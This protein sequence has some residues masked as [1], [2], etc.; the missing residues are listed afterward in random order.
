MGPSE[1][2]PKAASSKPCL[3]LPSP[4]PLWLCVGGG[5]GC[6]ADCGCLSVSAGLLLMWAPCPAQGLPAGAAK[7]C[8][9]YEGVAAP[10]RRNA[11]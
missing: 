7:Q 1:D 3:T 2:Q 10:S 8:Y 4:Q 5:T 11:A 9:L 6:L